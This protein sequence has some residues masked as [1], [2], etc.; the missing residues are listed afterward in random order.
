MVE[1]WTKWED[2]QLP[3]CWDIVSELDDRN[4]AITHGMVVGLWNEFLMEIGASTDEFILDYPS[5]FDP[6]IHTDFYNRV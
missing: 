3:G 1:K 5:L 2:N 4:F 6:E